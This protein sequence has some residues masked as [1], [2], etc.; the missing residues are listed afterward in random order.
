MTHSPEHWMRV[1]VDTAWSAR[2][3][4]APNPWVGCV[5]VCADGTFH[6]GAT[7]PPGGRHAEIVAIERAE[8]AGA[9]LTSA[10]LHSTLE[11]CSHHGR[12]GPCTDAIVARSIPRVVVGTLD[13]DSNVAG[14]GIAALRAAGIEVTVGVERDLVEEQL[15]PYLHHR[16]TRRPYVVMKMAATLDG[17]IAAADGT[18][19][20]ITSD[21]ARRRV[22]ELR[23]DSQA[24]CTGAGTV[25]A[26]DPELTVRHV[27]GPDPRRIVL[28]RAPKAA[29]VHPC[30]EWTEPIPQLLDRL[31]DEGVLQLLVEAGPRVAGS[32]HREG[33]VDRYVLHL[34]PALAGDDCPSVI[35]GATT[36]TISELWRG[37]IVATSMLGPDL[38]VILES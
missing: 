25:R 4:T 5:I 37:R 23:A 24:V 29:R 21:P 26:D 19:R 22:H 10:T 8:A 27:E 36:P 38:E 28:G 33:L 20:W 11:P 12:T 15:R 17:R 30:L 32:F 34:A 14:N 18:S 7:E 1:A 35:A 3:T 2:R 13:P 6:T 16:R 9:D 31:G